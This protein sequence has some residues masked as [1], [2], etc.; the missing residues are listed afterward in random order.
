MRMPGFTAEAALRKPTADYR[1]SVVSSDSGTVVPAALHAGR[2][3]YCDWDGCG[4]KPCL[5]ARLT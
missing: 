2:C 1:A 4:W 3:Y 5:I